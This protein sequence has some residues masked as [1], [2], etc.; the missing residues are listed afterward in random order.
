MIT[1]LAFFAFFGINAAVGDS[2]L[3]RQTGF[4][5]LALAESQPIPDLLLSNPEDVYFPAVTIYDNEYDGTDVYYT[6]DLPPTNETA[7]NVTVSGPNWW[8][9][10]LYGYEGCKK[11]GFNK[12]HIK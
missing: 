1:S 11:N 5:T 9:T 6:E 7:G 4:P 10:R 8:G 12:E 2:E 3:Q